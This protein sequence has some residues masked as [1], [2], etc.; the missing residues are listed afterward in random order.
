MLIDNMGMTETKGNIP[1]T[2]AQSQMLETDPTEKTKGSHG[3]SRRGRC[4]GGSTF[5]PTQSRTFM[6]RGGFRI[7]ESS[8]SRAV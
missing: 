2:V 3:Q 1:R 8:P 7:M 5:T 6:P 4:T